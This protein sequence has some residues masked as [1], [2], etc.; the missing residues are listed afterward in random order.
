MF[1]GNQLV[2]KINKSKI[3]KSIISGEKTKLDNELPSGVSVNYFEKVIEN[4]NFGL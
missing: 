3:A 2:C 4:G 1:I